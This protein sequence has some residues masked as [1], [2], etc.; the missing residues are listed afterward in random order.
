MS[1]TKYI[2]VNAD[3]FGYYDCVSKGILD[4]AHVGSVTA[5]GVFGNSPFLDTHLPW[6]KQ[7]SSLDMGVHLNLTNRAPLT[8]E[9]QVQMRRWNGCF[10][11][12]FTMIKLILTGRLSL[13]MVAQELRAQIIRCRT[14]DINLSF[15]NS[16]E[17]IHMLPPVFQIT[18]DLAIEY[19]IPHVRYSMPDAINSVAPGSLIRDLALKLLG[20]K[21]SHL[22]RL[23]VL[24][25]LGMAA[26]GKLD[27]TYLQHVLSRLKP[28]V[29]ELMCHPGACGAD[30]DTSS[31][32]SAYHQWKDELDTLKSNEFRTLCHQQNIKL[33]GYHQ[34]RI[35]D[36]KVEAVRETN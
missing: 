19:A 1:A 11:G 2:I 27:L 20:K 6:L 10:P 15:L 33:I 9:M 23:P 36:G 26:S 21:N 24:P 28:G 14:A 35:V 34:T 8:R 18:Q 29:Y 7:C 32:L 12:K 17:H 31:E 25:F 5:T 13:D 22:L 3:D 16:H 4:A 30:D